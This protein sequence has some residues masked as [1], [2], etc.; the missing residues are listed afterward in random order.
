MTHRRDDDLDEEIRAH[1]RMAIEERVARGESR[2]SAESAARRELGN[3]T[4]IKEVTRE[5]HR[6]VWLERLVQDVS[7]GWRALRRTPGFTVVAVLSLA[8]AIGAN[9]TIY[10]VANAFLTRPIP[11]ATE[12][13]RLVR[14]YRGRHGALQYR[15][16]AYVRANSSALTE[17]AGERML[18]V[19]V[20]NADGTER[21]TGALVTQ[22]YFS[23]LG[24]RAAAGRV[25]TAADSAQH[26][27]VL[28]HAYWR[29]R[30][31]GDPGAVGASLNING[32]PFTI[33][34][35]ADPAFV[36]SQMIWHP[37]IWFSPAAGEQLT[38][39]PFERWGGSLYTTARL[40][41]G[42]TLE[43]ANVE[44]LMLGQRLVAADTARGRNFS[45]RA[46]HADGVTAEM[47]PAATAVS[48]FLLFVV[49]LVLLLA[50]ANVAN[51]LLAR[52]T[53]RRREM[54]VRLALGAARKRL[55]RQLL[56]ESGIIAVAASTA[57]L[58]I[59]WVTADALARFVVSRSP[60]P[61]SLT[62][63]PDGRV[64][65]VTLVL[66]VVT[67]LLFGLL[68]ALRTTS[69]EILPVLREDAPQTSGRSRTRSVLVGAQLALC[70][71]LLA[72]AT[73][74]LRS[75]AN[76]RVIDPGFSAAGVVD[77]PIDLSTRRLDST[78]VDAFHARLLERARALP[79]VSSATLS[80]LVPL[81]GSN[82]QTGMWLP[83]T[84]DEGERAALMPYFNV[85]GRDY[86]ATLGIDLV[87]GR[88]FGRD[89][90]RVAIVN[91]EMARKLSPDGN[92]NGAMGRRFSVEGPSG[93][94]TT[95]VGV[96]RNVRYN[97]LGERTPEFIYLPLAAFRR[98]EMFLQV[99]G[100]PGTEPTLRRALPG[101]VRELDP[102]LP[103]VTASSLADDMR[104][105]LLP[106]QLGAALLG[107]FG[108]LALVLASMGVYGVASYSVA[109]RSRELGIR[110][111]L[112]A[113]RADVMR[114]VLGQS[115]RV[116]AIGTAVGLAGALAVA[117]LIASQLYGV[118]P[119]DPVTFIGMPLFLLSVALLATLVPARR[120][121]RADPVEALRHS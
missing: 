14:V 57:G 32:Q 120:A 93:P 24:V 100:A 45:L 98:E 89:D 112:G 6:G 31:A 5:Q 77:V 10:T 64:L 65:L 39:T 99:R 21:V 60:E 62:F 13:D 52:A 26:T 78:R 101:I 110:A 55:V 19:A 47:R 79:G 34:G 75:L 95:V 7:Y 12:T 63:T 117:R 119:T 121:T 109:Q 4:H 44:M 9:V 108:A 43:R 2:A 58:A 29:R 30:F 80:A 90:G 16:L 73:L 27:I 17:V 115:L 48:A 103:P 106:S 74:F 51:L 66:A 104:I 37:A 81:G 38:G 68:P 96:A 105:T 33:V 18:P 20:A 118:G 116:A 92:A 71:V 15:D 42:A 84:G 41:E 22:G 114:M 35:V 67:T 111:A 97:S 82:M 3:V 76:A 102:L 8:L 91:E 86:F 50:C 59:A 1:L 56:T 72:C 88:E 54:G 107:A 113:T 11:G 53:S 83:G 87:A 94:W 49:G 25:F 69:L 46:D 61:V 40:S 28:S 23:M 36:S 70:T 85:V